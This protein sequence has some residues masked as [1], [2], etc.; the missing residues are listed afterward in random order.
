[1]WSLLQL[2][3]CA[4][5]AWMHPQTLCKQVNVTVFQQVI[6]QKQAAYGSPTSTLEENDI[7]AGYWKDPSGMRL[8]TAGRWIWMSMARFQCKIYQRTGRYTPY[9]VLSVINP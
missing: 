1:M 9:I 5:V 4:I 7:P 2:L 3:N 8:A 6:L